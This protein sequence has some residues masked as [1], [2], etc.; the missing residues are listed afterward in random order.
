MET[1]ITNET[2]KSATPALLA[3]FLTEKE[4]G[5]EIEVSRKTLIRW[6]ALGI[7]PARTK[8]GRKVLYS[9]RAVQEWI[10]SC[11]QHRHKHDGPRRHG[12]AKRPS[13]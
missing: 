2:E 1:A 4:L 6:A 7:G 12:R 9:R 5:R 3:G 10:A 11:E 8:I 13:P